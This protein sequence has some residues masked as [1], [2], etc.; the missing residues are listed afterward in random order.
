M[1]AAS[2][3]FLL[4][5]CTQTKNANDEASVPSNDS[6]VGAPAGK[7]DYSQLP[8]HEEKIQVTFDTTLF[9]ASIFPNYKFESTID[10]IYPLI[11]FMAEGPPSSPGDDSEGGSYHRLVI[12]TSGIQNRIY[13]ESGDMN[14]NGEYRSIGSRRLIDDAEFV[15]KF[16][17][18]G[19]LSGVTFIDWN[20]W[21]SFV[22]E[23][24]GIEYIFKDIG[25]NPVTIQV[26]NK[27]PGHN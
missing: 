4:L 24:G 17:I 21:D 27:N 7:K 23:I 26:A 20:S 13:I 10:S 22:L 6:V 2:L 3:I 14:L 16:S 5:S 8:L 9:D 11:T 12:T 15:E 25:N 1:R 18:Q 19:K